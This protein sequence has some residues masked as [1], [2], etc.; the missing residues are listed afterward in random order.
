MTIPPSKTERCREC[1]EEAL[2]SDL[3]LLARVWY[4]NTCKEYRPLEE[5]VPTPPVSNAAA[6]PDSTRKPGEGDKT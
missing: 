1:G 6:E 2:I 4:C 3:S 5:D